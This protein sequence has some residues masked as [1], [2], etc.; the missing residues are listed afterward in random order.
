MGDKKTDFEARL[1]ELRAAYA[2]QLPAKLEAI[3][4]HW[5]SLHSSWELET[6]KLLHRLVHS[7]AG[8]GGSFGFQQLGGQ[9]REIEIELKGWLK[10]QQPPDKQQMEGLAKR[11]ADLPQAVST[12][13]QQP[14]VPTPASTQQ[15]DNKHQPLIYLLENDQADA[16]ALALQLERFGYRA[17]AFNNT[18]DFDAAVSG[19]RPDA[20]IANTKLPEG[21]TAGLAAMQRIQG[22]LESPIPLIFISSHTDFNGRL[23]AV[24]AGCNDYLVK[25]VDAA[26]L[27]NRLDHLTQ[28][29]EKSDPL[30]ILLIDNDEALAAHYTLIL[31]QAGME[32]ISLTQPAETLGVITDF[33]PDLILMDLYMPHCSGLELAKII[34]QQETYLSIPIVFLSSESDPAKQYGAMYTGGDDF[35]TKPIDSELLVSSVTHRARRARALTKLMVE[36]SLTGLLKHTKIKEL[37]AQESSRA[38][39]ENI[40]LSFVM[41]DIDHFKGVN[42]QYGHMAGDHVI[43]TLARLLRQGLRKSDHVGRYGGEEFALILPGSGATTSM[44]V[45]NKLRTAFEGLHFIHGEQTFSVTFSAGIA[46]SPP[47]EEPDALNLAA[48]EALYRAKQ[49]G[50]NRVMVAKHHKT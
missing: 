11:L 18:T 14:P 49:Q 5:Q 17:Q 22:D 25:P 50:R 15:D 4:A 39:R 34:R 35:L 43:K 27:V 47:Y 33:Q 44:R 8:S 29:N 21:D 7:L 12:T 40:P 32:V 3:E 45:V 42:D 28:S 13:P 23:E 41:I 31:R 36:D 37:L 2:S 26:I 16:E 24:R 48:D 10:A 46:T 38:Q 1:E 9:A 30:R 6:A 20:I 19:N